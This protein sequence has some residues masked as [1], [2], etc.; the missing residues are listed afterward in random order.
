MITELDKNFL[1][2]QMIIIGFT[3]GMHF[4]KSD[5]SVMGVKRGGNGT[6]YTS[7]PIISLGILMANVAD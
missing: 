3:P 1:S 5:K 6:Q 7:R 4:R 2:K